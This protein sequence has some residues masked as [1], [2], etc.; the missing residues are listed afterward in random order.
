MSLLA[1]LALAPCLHAT[2]PDPADSILNDPARGYD[3][4]LVAELGTLWPL[5]NT[6]QLS[7]SGTRFDYVEDG[8]QDN[9]AFFARLSAELDIG[10]R[11]TV[12]L[13]YQPLDLRTQALLEENEVID[14]EVFFEGTAMDVRYGFDFYRASWLW[15]AQA[16][17]QRET[18][19]GLSL[20]IRNAALDFTSVDG[21]KRRVNRDI[22]PVPALKVRTRQPLGNTAWWGVE[23]DGMYAPVKYINGSG[24]DVV[25]A[26]LD[27]SVRAGLPLA[28]GGEAFLNLRYLGGGAEGTSKDTS[29]PGDGWV[30]NWLHF[31]SLSMGLALR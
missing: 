29:G 4:G 31:V 8:G 19:V 22:G 30:S 16:D 27:A 9:L 10:P 2:T 23:A 13:L 28:H 20:Q 25:G 7:K 6:I 26:I 21:E 12:V 14:D 18:A 3:L 1:V 24:T 15:D 5:A 11:H 17:P